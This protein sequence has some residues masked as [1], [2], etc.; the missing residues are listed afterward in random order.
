MSVCLQYP[1]TEISFEGIIE[2]LGRLEGLVEKTGANLTRHERVVLDRER[3]KLKNRIVG[4]V[5]EM[6]QAFS[7]ADASLRQMFA[8]GQFT[9]VKDSGVPDPAGEENL[10][11]KARHLLQLARLGQRDKV[12]LKSLCPD[13]KLLINRYFHMVQVGSFTCHE[14]RKEVQTNLSETLEL[15]KGKKQEQMG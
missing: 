13:Y 7:N 14:A 6:D 9:R 8:E 2:S 5:R 4:M 10:V 12:Y 15:I 11:Q 1:K 3:K